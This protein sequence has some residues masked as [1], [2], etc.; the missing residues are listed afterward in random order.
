VARSPTDFVPL[1]KAP[2][3]RLSFSVSA[4]VFQDFFRPGKPPQDGRIA[5]LSRFYLFSEGLFFFLQRPLD[6]PL[7]PRSSTALAKS[8]AQENEHPRC[9]TLP[10]FFVSPFGWRPFLP[11]V[12]FLILNQPASAK[13]R[14][15]QRD[16]QIPS[17]PPPSL[18]SQNFFGAQV[19]PLDFLLLKDARKG[20]VFDENVRSKRDDPCPSAFSLI[21]FHWSPRSKCLSFRL[22]VKKPQP[23]RAKIDKRADPRVPFPFVHLLLLFPPPTRQRPSFVRP[24]LSAA[25][26]GRRGAFWPLS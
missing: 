10:L 12:V 19:F 1:R 3:F 14:R 4:L 15:V 13:C 7:S 20:R 17:A 23:F 5:F 25:A 11:P 26:R 21:S 22:L 9:P 24:L 18:L 2:L 16:A 6:P 8:Q